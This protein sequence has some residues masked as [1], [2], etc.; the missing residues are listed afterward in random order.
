M[1]CSSTHE[2]A[3]DMPWFV[4]LALEYVWQ[5]QENTKCPS[6]VKSFETVRTSR[7]GLGMISEEAMGTQEPILVNSSI[8][9]RALDVTWFVRF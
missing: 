2:P 8:H 1:E 6:G 4:C 3:L 5:A 9:V 7:Q